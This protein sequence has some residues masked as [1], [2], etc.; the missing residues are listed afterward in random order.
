[1]FNFLLKNLLLSNYGTVGQKLS[2]LT[3][4]AAGSSVAGT[5]L[6][7]AQGWYYENVSFMV[8]VFIA[9]AVDHIAGS[10][11]HH[12][13]LDDFKW[14]KNLA[15]LLNKV[16][17]VVMGYI[18]FEMV[19]EILKDTGFLAETFKVFLQL[20]VAM[21]PIS[22]GLKNL[23]IMSNKRFP[24]EVWFKKIDRFNETG[25]VGIFKNQNHENNGT[26]N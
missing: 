12:F 2:I 26:V 6:L 7:R 25:D 13:W 14:P 3:V 9:I 16:G 23:W 24:P 17:V 15:G 5:L 10:L 1:M 21:W 8:L 18:L 22:S 11:V 19:R 20:S 4:T